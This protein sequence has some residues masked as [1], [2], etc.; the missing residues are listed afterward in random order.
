MALVL[1]ID[2]ASLARSGERSIVPA[3]RAIPLALAIEM[4]GHERDGGA[5]GLLFKFLNR[6]GLLCKINF[7]LLV[8]LFFRIGGSIS[9]PN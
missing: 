4:E 7:E 5:E 1:A 2:P 6:E 9:L 3:G 8:R